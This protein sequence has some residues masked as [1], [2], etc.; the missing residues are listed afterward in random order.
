MP[1]RASELNALAVQRLKSPGL[2]FVGGVAGLALQI[3]DTGSRSWTLRLSVAGR[4]RDMGLGAYPDVTLA[5]ARERAREA[6]ELVRRGVDPIEQRRAA[7]SALKASVAAALT[8]RQTATA[9][10]STHEAGWKNA[11][12]AQQWRNTLE[13]YAYPVMGD[14]LVRDVQKEHVLAALRPIW[15]EK[16][17]TATRLRG[18]IELVLSYAMQAGYRPEGLNPAR[19]RGG[20]DKLL[21][22]PAKVAKAEHHPALPLG[23]VGAFMQRLRAAPGMGARALE[24]TILTAARSGEVRG[25]TWAEIDLQDKVWSVPPSRMK[26]GNEHR[27][28]LSTAAIAL[29]EALPRIAGTDLVF[30]APRGGQLSDMTL[31]AVLRRMEI[32]AVPHGFRSTFRDWAAERTTFPREAAEMALAHTIESKVEAAYRRGDLFEKRRVMMAEWADFLS[33]EEQPAKVIPMR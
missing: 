15:T 13:A 23:Q 12:H 16:N 8:F 9:Y 32:P 28:P 20:L 19:W 27:V 17:E 10:I 5:M 4:R 3:T 24:F 1:A 22:A 2:H 7:T 11:K 25:A 29:L 21:P 26:A 30:P 31:S 18:R 14:L 6:R 33:L